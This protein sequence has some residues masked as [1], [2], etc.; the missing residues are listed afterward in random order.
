M[1]IKNE[2]AK[3]AVAE[4]TNLLEVAQATTQTASLAEAWALW[5][6]CD[7]LRHRRLCRSGGCC[8]VSGGRER[9]F[10]LRL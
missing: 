2:S 4:L 9:L 10:W 3:V 7:R 5:S 8:I 1:L 6:R